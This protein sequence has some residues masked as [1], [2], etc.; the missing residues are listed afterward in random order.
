MHL[1][2]VPRGKPS[3]VWVIDGLASGSFT[4][5]ALMHCIPCAVIMLSICKGG[6][7]LIVSTVMYDKMVLLVTLLPANKSQ[8]HN[9]ILRCSSSA[10]IV[11]WCHV[12]SWFCLVNAQTEASHV[13]TVH[14]FS[15]LDQQFSWLSSSWTQNAALSS[16]SIHWG[17]KSYGMGPNLGLLPLLGPF[18]SLFEPLKGREKVML[19]MWMCTSASD[20]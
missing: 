6:P 18:L 13:L 10:F 20:V 9:F 2:K 12:S 7:R 8:C 14:W 11:S 3:G 19:C 16:F 17:A 15:K 1:G 5:T 4:F